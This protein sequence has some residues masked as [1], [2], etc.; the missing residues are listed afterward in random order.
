METK[1]NKIVEL[2][3]CNECGLREWYILDADSDISH[4]G[5]GCLHCK[6]G[7][8]IFHLKYKIIEVVE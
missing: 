8:F 4:E 6:E 1:E 2:L 3:Q 5:D 7:V